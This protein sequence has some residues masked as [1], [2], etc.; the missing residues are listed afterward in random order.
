M[1]VVSTPGAGRW[2]ARIDIERR[3]D[4]TLHFG[5]QQIGRMTGGEIFTID[6]Q[7]VPLSG[8]LSLGTRAG[9]EHLTIQPDQSITMDSGH[10]TIDATGEVM[11]TRGGTARPAH[12]HITG[13]RPEGASL[14]AILLVYGMMKAD[15][16]TR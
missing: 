10:L 8:R 13:Y 5:G 2:F 11:I 1:H 3:E 6:G 12:V 14:A 9:R 4:G 15:L 7:R 16:A